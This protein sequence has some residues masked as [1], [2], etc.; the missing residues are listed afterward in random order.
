[1][2]R[3]PVHEVQA[4]GEE[5]QARVQG[6]TGTYIARPQLS[7]L[8]CL[9]STNTNRGRVQSHKEVGRPT[10]AQM[11]ETMTMLGQVGKKCPVC[12][13]FIQKNEGCHIMMCGTTAHGSLQV[14]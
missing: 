4:G 6:R 2:R 9:P 14:R 8:N 12:S 1:M 11:E 10:E 3:P 7:A 5:R 13:M